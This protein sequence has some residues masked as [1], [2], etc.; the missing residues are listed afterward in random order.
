[1]ESSLASIEAKLGRDTHTHPSP[2]PPCSG[3]CSSSIG[4]SWSRGHAWLQGV[5]GNVVLSW[6][7]GPLGPPKGNTALYINRRRH[8]FLLHQLP[9]GLKGI[10]CYQAYPSQCLCSCSHFHWKCAFGFG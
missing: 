6:L 9:L 2:L 4:E 3:V 5:L 10:N 1:M 8:V 7:P